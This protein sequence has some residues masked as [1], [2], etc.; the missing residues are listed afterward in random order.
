L[1][2]SLVGN[3]FI[4]VK[5]LRKF[6]SFV[7]KDA[8][9][10]FDRIESVARFIR[11]KDGDIRSQDL[12]LQSSKM[13]IES[14]ARYRLSPLSSLARKETR[15]LDWLKSANL[16]ELWNEFKLP[17]FMINVAHRGH[18]ATTTSCF[19]GDH[20]L[21]KRIVKSLRGIRQ[22]TYAYV[23]S[24]IAGPTIIEEIELHEDVL[25]HHV[26][27][28]KLEGKTEAYLWSNSSEQKKAFL[29][30]I[31]DGFEEPGRAAALKSLKSVRTVV[32][33]ETFL[34]LCAVIT[35]VR[36]TT[37]AAVGID[38]D[39]LTMYIETFLI[40][41]L[42]KNALSLEELS[43][44]EVPAVF[45]VSTYRFL[46]TT[47]LSLKSVFQ[48]HE[49]VGAPYQLELGD[50]LNGRLFHCLLHQVLNSPKRQEIIQASMV[51][52][53]FQAGR[54]MKTLHACC[55]IK[56]IQ[57]LSETKMKNPIE[58]KGCMGLEALW[59]RTIVNIDRSVYDS[60]PVV[61][62]KDPISDGDRYLNVPEPSWGL[63]RPTA[64]VAALLPYLQLADKSFGV[65]SS[66]AI[67]QKNM[68]DR[69]RDEATL[70]RAYAKELAPDGASRPAALDDFQQSAAE[71]INR[72]DSILVC[73]PTGAG[74]THV[75]F[76][77]AV[78]RFFD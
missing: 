52:I 21:H 66:H 77:A 71:A 42:L 45:G 70:L 59:V 13:L 11:E 60:T 32:G 65:P 20:D 29:H 35:A 54:L 41:L 3:D 67:G 64:S 38:S 26:Q 33:N 39:Q 75:S 37:Y 49:A 6:H 50:L 4:P 28:P 24:S 2:G 36:S 23:C 58:G 69:S 8:F 27:V 15:C 68:N 43:H 16:L 7:A 22:H 47:H 51:A 34:I 46:S 1:L 57:H 9:N 53:G 72:G 14:I 55:D 44:V 63:V 74:K 73:A 5:S 40:S 10:P 12:F 30:A 76:E 48:L 61:R 25:R 18:F 19:V 62:I 31:L 56:Q 17:S 78:F